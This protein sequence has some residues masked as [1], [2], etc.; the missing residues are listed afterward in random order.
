[1]LLTV[2]MQGVALI[3]NKRPASGRSGRTLWGSEESLPQAN[4]NASSLGVGGEGCVRV[5]CHCS[6]ISYICD[7][8]LFCMSVSSNIYDKDNGAA[9]VTTRARLSHLSCSSLS[10]FWQGAQPHLY[11]V[12]L[13]RLYRILGPWVMLTLASEEFLPPFHGLLLCVPEAVPCSAV[14]RR[15]LP[16]SAG[17]I[18]AHNTCLSTA[19]FYSYKSQ[20]RE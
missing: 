11:Q 9:A 14:Q 12:L 1:M 15:P 5:G 2:L 18:A 17:E 7:M 16:L 4:P 3:T 13:T 20:A 6:H 19:A 10:G 8:S